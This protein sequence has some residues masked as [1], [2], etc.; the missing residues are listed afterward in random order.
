MNGIKCFIKYKVF[1]DKRGD[2]KCRV[3]VYSKIHCKPLEI[4]DDIEDIDTFN[5]RAA[6]R[7][8]R[9]N[10]GNTVGPLASSKELV[11]ESPVLR[12]TKQNDP[13]LSVYEGLDEVYVEYYPDSVYFMCP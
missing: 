10:I 11:T 2:A 7:R 12:S 6:I 8:L 5:P 3:T 1:E 9:I 4:I 13:T